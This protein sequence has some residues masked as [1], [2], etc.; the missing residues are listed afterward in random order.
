MGKSKYSHKEALAD[1]VIATTIHDLRNP[2]HG[3]GGLLDIL[4]EELE[5]KGISVELEG[6]DILEDINEQVE[7]LRA[8]ENYLVNWLAENNQK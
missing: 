4:R 7:K 1:T 5:E 3:L 2:L 8:L 6:R